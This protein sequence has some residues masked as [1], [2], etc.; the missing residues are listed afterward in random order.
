LKPPLDL[1]RRLPDLDNE[2]GC[3]TALQ[4]YCSPNILLRWFFWLRLWFLTVALERY[5]LKKDTV[6][7]FGCGSGV[8]LPTLAVLFGKVTAI[9]RYSR[10]SRSVCSAMAIDNVDIV[11]GDIHSLDLKK[12]GFDAIVAADVLEH[13]PDAVL[14]VAKIENW[15]S[16]EGKLF[17]SLP[18]EN[19]SY[20]FARMLF[21]KKKPVDHYHT[22]REVERVLRENGFRKIFIVSCP[23]FI[24]LFALYRISV[25]QRSAT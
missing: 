14:P 17:V 2:E 23:L 22:A 20:C 18:T 21:R 10:Q 24:P 5:A 25:W 9:D 3:N 1:L 12:G 15:L 6:L 19:L 7:D 8:Y 13:F 4:V 16:P 11:T